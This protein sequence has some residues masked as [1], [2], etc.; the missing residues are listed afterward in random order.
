[1]SERQDKLELSLARLQALLQD[2]AERRCADAA[3]S[4]T[5]ESVTAKEAIDAVWRQ[6]GV[7]PSTTQDNKYWMRPLV[8]ANLYRC[9]LSARKTTLVEWNTLPA[10]AQAKVRALGTALGG[11]D[12][13]HDATPGVV[14]V[15]LEV[16]PLGH[17]AGCIRLSY[18][19]V[20]EDPERC[21]VR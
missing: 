21:L 16:L 7:L 17:V 8:Q 10:A 6:V 5:D 3:K 13:A 9:P 4:R 2:D 19:V 12:G 15:P 14:E 20:Q 18:H 11:I 1:M